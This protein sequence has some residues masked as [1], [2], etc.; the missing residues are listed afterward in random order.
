MESLVA[1]HIFQVFIQVSSSHLKI[2]PVLT[3]LQTVL[4][5]DCRRTWT[6]FALVTSFH[7]DFKA[8]ALKQT[9][10]YERRWAM[11]SLLGQDDP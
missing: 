1:V 11:T 2:E 8:L 4:S 5:V 9:D 7:I 10:Y 6:R 3:L